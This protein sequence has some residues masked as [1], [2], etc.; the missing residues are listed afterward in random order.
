VGAGGAAASTAAG[1]QGGEGEESTKKLTF[2]EQLWDSFEVVWRKRVEPSQRLLEQVTALLHNRAELERKYGESLCGFQIACELQEEDSVH[3]AVDAML[4]NFKNRG[5]QSLE[6]AENIDQDIVAFFEAVIKQHRDTSTRIFRDV[7]VLTRYLSEKRQSYE[8]AVRRYASRCSEAES[9]AQECLQGLAMKTID[10][11]K[12]AQKATI[13]S[14]QARAAEHEYY[15][16]IDQANKAQFVYDT[17]M[18]SVFTALQ[19]LEEKKALCMKDG[20]M[21][22]IVYETSWLRNMQYDI[23]AIIKSNEG[24]DAAADVQRFIKLHEGQRK[25]TSQLAPQAFWHLG[26]FKD[27]SPMDRLVKQRE[28]QESIKRFMDTEFKEPLKAL[29]AGEADPSVPPLKEQLDQIRANITD[30]RRRSALCQVLRQELLAKS[31]NT[32]D[33]N[34]AKTVTVPLASLDLLATL[35]R[36]ALDSCEEQADSWCGRDIM[37]LVNHINA[38]GEGGK[39]VLLITRVYNHALWNK[40]SFWEEVLTMGLCEAHS[41]EAL[42]RRVLPAGSQFSQPPMT[43]FLEKFVGYMMAFGINFA[44]AQTS[45]YSTLRKLQQVLGASQKTYAKLLLQHHAPPSTQTDPPPGETSAA[46]AAAAAPSASASGYPAEGADEPQPDGWGDSSGGRQ[47]E[48]PPAE[49]GGFSGAGGFDDDFEA[50][51]LGLAPE[52]SPIGTSNPGGGEAQGEAAD[53]N[54]SEGDTTQPP[55]APPPAPAPAPAAA[56]S[57][58]TLERDTEDA[59]KSPTSE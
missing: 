51:A 19:E 24:I 1:A 31:P 57:S 52:G 42:T 45:V 55:P 50:V 44:Q 54:G 46:G 14:K 59:A 23:D 56:A 8:K 6:L 47:M 15:A 17:H 53:G 22:L 12:L 33:L 11:M 32:E 29:L 38:I 2:A 30:G 49:G 36:A 27:A 10:R 26:S 3:S 28:V 4:G 35:L 5:E 58:A 21:K 7:Q 37:V 25:A 48:A 18:P 41:V 43:P 40:V 34:N 13:L 16:C 39:S 20:L 9:V